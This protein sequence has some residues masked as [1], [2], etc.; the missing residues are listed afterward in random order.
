MRRRRLLT[1]VFQVH[2]CLHFP[3]NCVHPGKGTPT[4]GMVAV[5]FHSLRGL[6][7][8]PPGPG[9]DTETLKQDISTSLL[10]P[11]CPP[12]TLELTLS[13]DAFQIV[14]LFSVCLSLYIHCIII[15]TTGNPTWQEQ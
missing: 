2:E 12:R 10:D 5:S 3:V 8:P 13:K 7:P 6:L 9:K 14:S 11:I 1:G 4:H 15:D